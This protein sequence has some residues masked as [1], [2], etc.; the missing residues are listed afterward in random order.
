MWLKIEYI[1]YLLCYNDRLWIFMSFHSLFGIFGLYLEPILLPAFFLKHGISVNTKFT[2]DAS[3]GVRIETLESLIKIFPN[4]R[5]LN[6]KLVEGIDDEGMLIY[7][8]N[9]KLGKNFRMGEK[10]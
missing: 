7:K 8:K 10:V 5:M 6:V 4:V 3:C 2:Y 1:N 9:R